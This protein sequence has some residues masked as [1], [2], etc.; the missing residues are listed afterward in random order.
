MVVLVI[1]VFL[2]N[3]RAVIIPCITIPV[4]LIGTLAIMSLFGFSINT[5]TLFGLILAV[6]IVVDDAI[7][8]VEAVHA[9]LDL[10][11]KSAKLASIDAMNEISGA[12]IS[13]TLVMASVFI[14]VSFM[15]GTSGAFYRE[16]GIT[17]AI[18]IIISALNALTLSPALCAI[19]LKPKDEEGKERKMSMVD[20]FHASFNAAYGKVQIGRAH[21]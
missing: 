20:R 15:G 14:P 19:L 12:I 6:A 21:V 17:M 7:V 10:G 4:S 13:I 5:L 2:Q 18:S 8:V 9:K 1:F 3:W 16:F 11:Y